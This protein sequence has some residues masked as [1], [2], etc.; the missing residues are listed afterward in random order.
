M[1]ILFSEKVQPR[2]GTGRCGDKYPGGDA[3]AMG[4]GVHEIRKQL[5]L[6]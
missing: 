2:I 4:T 3:S 6:E 5:L 1:T